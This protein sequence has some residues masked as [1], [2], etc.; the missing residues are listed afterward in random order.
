MEWTRGSK[1][2]LVKERR[3]E[4]LPVCE[5]DV[6]VVQSDVVRVSNISTGLCREGCGIKTLAV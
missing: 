3:Q 1:G 4:T 5:C 2:E 6:T